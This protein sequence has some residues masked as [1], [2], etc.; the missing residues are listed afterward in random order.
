M[1]RILTILLLTIYLFS[2]TELSQLLKLPLLIDHFIDHKEENKDVT[3]WEY[4]YMHYA[5][6]KDNSTDSNTD[7]KL[8]FKSHDSFITV[9]SNIYTPLFSEF[10]ITK[11]INLVEKN[12]LKI[13]E[14]FILPSV[15][16]NIWQPPRIA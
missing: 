14:C 11:P 1:K 4:L 12:T 13:T 9:I 2:T 16:S 3:I 5:L 7:K 10:I 15:L 6:D 8:P